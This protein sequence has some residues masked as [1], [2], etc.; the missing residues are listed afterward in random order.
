MAA[1][2]TLFVC[3]MPLHMVIVQKS[4][5]NGKHLLRARGP[6]ELRVGHFSGY[7]EVRLYIVLPSLAWLD[8]LF[9]DP[10]RGI[11]IHGLVTG[12]NPTPGTSNGRWRAEA[13]E[14]GKE[15]HKTSPTDSVSETVCSPRW[16]GCSFPEYS[17]CR[18]VLESLSHALQCTSRPLTSTRT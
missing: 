14:R 10:K 16:R 18:S 7:I 13:R 9:S 12:E 2:L 11:H 17:S 5:V 1:I 8:A 15:H 4:S 3:P 6:R